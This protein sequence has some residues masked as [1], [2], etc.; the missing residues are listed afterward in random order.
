M[1]FVSLLLL[2]VSILPAQSHAVLEAPAAGSYFPLDVGDRWVYRIDDRQSTASY[3]TWRIDRMEERNGATYAVMTIE[4]PGSLFAEAWFRADNSGRVYSRSGN[5]ERLFLDP[6]GQPAPEA[7]LQVTGKGGASTAL[8]DFPDAL[9]YQNHMPLVLETGT[10]ARGVG[11]LSSYATMLTGSSGGFTQGRTLVEARVAGISFSLPAPSVQLGLE[12]L[13][14][15]VSGKQ[16]TNCA[17]PCYFVACGFVPGAD[18]PG[19]YKPCARARVALVNWPADQSRTVQ[20]QLLTP[21]GPAAY[22]QTLVL[23]TTA[24]ESALFIQVP[25]YS[26]PNQ[27]LPAGT[28]QLTATSADGAAQASLAVRIR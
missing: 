21:D 16:V 22:H 9:S 8:G 5:G 18:S 3:Q 11:L 26:S 10:L 25:L 4:G 2:A 1:R 24:Q 19:T 17:V 15:D 7:E 28:Y 6:S 23:N 12:S 13:D 20:L 27:P 14:L